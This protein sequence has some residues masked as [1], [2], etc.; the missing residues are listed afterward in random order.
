MTTLSQ[1][2]LE[3]FDPLN[4]AVVFGDEPMPVQILKPFKT[5]MRGESYNLAEGPTELPSC[6]AIF[7]MARGVAEARA[8]R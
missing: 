1:S 6:V 7:L 3:E 4:D 2:A 5:E 8:R